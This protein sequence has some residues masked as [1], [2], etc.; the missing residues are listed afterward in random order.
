MNG[1]PCL[2]E[3]LRAYG[4][5]RG[6]TGLLHAVNRGRRLVGLEKCASIGD[7]PFDEAVASINRRIKPEKAIPVD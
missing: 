5:D 4:W 6:Q 3:A 1:R 7:V 2:K